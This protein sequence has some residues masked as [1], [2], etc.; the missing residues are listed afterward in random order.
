[1]NV[2]SVLAIQTQG[3]ANM[4]RW[5]KTFRIEYSQDCVTFNKV[6]DIDGNDL[7]RILMFVFTCTLRCLRAHILS[8][9]LF[10]DVCV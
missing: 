8:Y 1:M 5:V 9:L 4:D 6:L 2:S 7:V 10:K 3:G